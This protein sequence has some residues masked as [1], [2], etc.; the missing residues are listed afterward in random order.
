MLFLS[1]A[2]R[3]LKF[4]RL[5]PQRIIAVIIVTGLVLTA[6]SA[7]AR[8]EAPARPQPQGTSGGKAV[9]DQFCAGCHTIGGGKLVGPDLKDVTKRRDPQWVKNFILDTAKMLA[10]D[11][12]A[13]QLLK[14]SNNIAMPTLNLSAVQVSQLLDFLSD[15]AS[16]STAITTGAAAPG[17]A[18]NGERIFTGEQPL[19]N[20]GPYCLACHSVNGAGA[21]GGGGLGP[22]LTN[23]VRRLGEPGLMASLKT[24]AFPTMIGPFLNQPLTAQELADMVAFLREA[25]RWQAPVEVVAAGT[26]TTNALLFFGLGLLGAGLLFAVMFYVWEGIKKNYFPRLPVRKV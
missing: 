14:E 20:H 17:N 4:L 15:P 24:I 23:V 26:L 18:I 7:A 16:V 21:L 11:P 22:D 3:S 1:Y 19:S 5:R 25:D 6:F 9:F 12:V 13:Q 10:S 8:A 2:L